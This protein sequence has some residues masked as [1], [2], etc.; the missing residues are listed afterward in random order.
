[1]N[2]NWLPWKFIIRA[3]ATKHGF[4]DPIA[5]LSHLSKFSQPSEVSE[6]IELLRAGVVFHARG[7]IN[8][9]VIQH[10]LDWVW[11]YWIER[12]FNPS[13]ASFV[14][15]AF[16][17]THV[18][19]THRNWTAV[20][21]PDYSQL[22]ILDPRGL[23]T[24]HLDKWSLDAWI[25]CDD[26]GELLP[27]RDKNTQQ[28]LDHNN[29]VSIVTN[30]NSFGLELITTADVSLVKDKPV[31]NFKVSA[32]SNSAAWLIISLRPYNPEGIAFIHDVEMKENR[33]SWV[34]DKKYDVFFDQVIDQYHA[35]TF[36]RGDV[37]IHLR[38]AKETHTQHCDIGLVTSAALFRIEKPST[39]TINLQIPLE[40]NSISKF[41]LTCQNKATN[42]W[43]ENLNKACQL[44]I[45]DKHIK[46][47][48]ETSIRTLI[49][50]SPEETFPGPYTYKRFW[51]RDAAFI[52]CGLIYSGLTDRAERSL[53]YFPTRQ[54]HGGYFHSQEGEWDSNG[55]ALWI[56][57]RFYECT[58]RLPSSVDW[59]TSIKKA[60][61]WIIKK[62]LSD[63]LNT[64]HAG[65]LPAGFSAEHLGPNDFYYWDDFWSV[66][67]LGAAAFF[68]EYF[69]DKKYMSVFAR[70]KNS[71]MNAIEESLSKTINHIKIAALP[72]SPYRRLDAGAIGSLA[73]GYPLQLLAPNDERLMNTIE[74]ILQK[75]F[76]NNG[77]FQDMIHSGV[78]PY[79][80][81]HVAQVLMRAGDTRY[82]DLLQRVAELAS[83]TGQWPEA[84]HPHT[85]GGC[86]GDGQHA[87]AAAEW[88]ILLRN[89]FIREENNSLIFASGIPR[90]WLDSQ[91][92][93][94][95]GPAPTSFGNVFIRIKQVKDKI[96]I[97]WDATWWKQPDKIEIKI[98]GL[99]ATECKAN[100]SSLVLTA[101]NN[102]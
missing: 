50:C 100:V 84:I 81:L 64:P 99:K 90:Q 47:L 3:V 24:P 60:G 66:S 8:S 72:A 96:T 59:W 27:S 57:Q 18:N 26:G 56:L 13:D 86:M 20:G 70:Q 45:P 41:T 32:K 76:V 46:Y 39:R 89:C 37:Y 51:F 44:S 36:N 7:L 38:E 9:R 102:V 82:F 12:Q 10:N 49:L 67:G 5:V 79:L 19:L 15:R 74:F 80:T 87:W 94:C 58:N 98:P 21:V 85:L 28:Y 62:R 42:T 16:S 54:T 31:C 93:L 83:P 65:L 22:P 73:A 34:I 1:M 14:P 23:L 4:L 53:R 92:E 97:A 78:N 2:F 43:E 52:L 71:L 61:K 91:E 69:D 77:F 63:N 55:E 88:I 33:R 6:P 95:F 29:G 68:A 75:C 101:E 48:Y 35:S 30:T 17:I 25:I 11:P 40:S